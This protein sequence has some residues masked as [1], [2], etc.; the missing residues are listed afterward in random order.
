MQLNNFTGG[1]NL[2]LSP[3][4]IGQNEGVVYT[5]IDAVKG[6][7]A[8]LNLDTNLGIPVSKYIYNFKDNWISSN[9]YKDYVEFQEKLYYSDGVS[10]PQKSINGTVYQ[11]LGIKKPS[12]KPTITFNSG[13][14]PFTGTYQYCYTYY[15]SID[16]TESQPSAF[17]LELSGAGLSINVTVI[18]STDSQ[19]DKIRV[20]RLGNNISLMSLV[21][22]ISNI[23][24]TYIDIWPDT[25]IDGSILDSYNNGQAPVGLNYLTEANAMLFGAVKDKLWYSEVAYVN[26]WNDFNYIDF[27]SEITGIGNTQNGLLVFTKYKT[28][29]V[30]GNSPSTLSKYLLDGKQGCISHKSIAFAKNTLVW[31]SSD[32]ICASSGGV[33]E[34]ISREKLNKI[35]LT[36]IK[37]SI[38]LED[39]YYLSYDNTTIMAD[40]RFGIVF[41]K[42]DISPDSFFLYSDIVYYSNITLHSMFT[43]LLPRSLEFTSGLY[44]DGSITNLKNYK[45]L[46]INSTGNLTLSTYINNT[47]VSTQ[48]LVNGVEEIKL[49]QQSRL[50]YNI[51]FN[52]LGT[53]TVNEIEYKAE[54]RQNGR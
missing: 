38:V 11:N 37:D 6:A 19:V 31:A 12:N 35:N 4:L 10:I 5:N 47:L 23:S 24:Q 45:T 16:G 1:L 52:I 32:G 42:L 43:S 39:I 54:G 26:S 51:R 36:N 9:S 17:S 25:S 8:P 30:T 3:H 21:A 44:S 46:Y 27:D 7:L 13:T 18:A 15:N 50:G 48:Q 40:F 29:I 53:G 14:T 28:Y 20:Y 22:S 41:S 33:I 49:P 34:V 2:R